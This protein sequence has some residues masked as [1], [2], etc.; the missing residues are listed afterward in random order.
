MEQRDVNDN[1]ITVGCVVK[2]IAENLKAYHVPPGGYGKFQGGKFHPDPLQKFMAIP[3]GLKG[4]VTKVYNVQD[5]SAQ[6]PIQVKFE[7]N[8]DDDEIQSPMV[9]QMHFHTYE[10]QVVE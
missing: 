3:V 10:V 7:P 9:F 2:V 8:D 4:V 1:V 6:T 5:I